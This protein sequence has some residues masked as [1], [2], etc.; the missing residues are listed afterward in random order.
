MNRL[1]R[2]TKSG[3]LFAWFKNDGVDCCIDCCIGYF[4][5]FEKV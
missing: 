5:D 4:N 1:I 2:I 3:H